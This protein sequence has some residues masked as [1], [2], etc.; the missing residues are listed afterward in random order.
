MNNVTELVFQLFQLWSGPQTFASLSS[1]CI[2]CSGLDDTKSI[3]DSRLYHAV[4]K[5]I[6]GQRY[7][8]Q[9]SP[10]VAVVLLLSFPPLLLLR[11]L[12]R[13]GLWA[14]V[15]RSS[16][17]APSASVLS[18]WCLGQLSI[19]RDPPPSSPGRFSFTSL[20]PLRKL[21]IDT[22]LSVTCFPC[23]CNH[24]VHY[25]QISPIQIFKA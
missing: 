6:L 16:P 24:Q 12:G 9:R 1:G 25:W 22:V 19:Q 13:A 10:S 5:L 14:P 20:G 4:E 18:S 23:R 17:S 3:P 11:L 8:E 15:L 21:L 7:K 2:I